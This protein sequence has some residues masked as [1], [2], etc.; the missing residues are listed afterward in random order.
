MESIKCKAS[1]QS[2]LP[3]IRYVLESTLYRKA[4]SVV[5]GYNK[6]FCETRLTRVVE[7]VRRHMQ[8]H[9]K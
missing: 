2:G 8:V 5:G 6:L 9:S 3:K 1:N 7:K 4:N